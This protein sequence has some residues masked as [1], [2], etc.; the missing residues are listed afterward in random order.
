MQAAEYS[1][2][3]QASLH[4]PEVSNSCGLHALTERAGRLKAETEGIARRLQRR[5]ASPD[6]TEEAQ[7][8]QS[9]RRSSSA[10]G[11]DGSVTAQGCDE[12]TWRVQTGAE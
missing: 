8:L 4:D 6:G 3:F 7:L 1:V 5:T 10:P 11:W 12:R 2:A 9:E